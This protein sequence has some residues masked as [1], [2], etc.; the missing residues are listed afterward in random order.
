MVIYQY[1]CFTY[2]NFWIVS[3]ELAHTLLGQ[4]SRS[5][6]ASKIAMYGRTLIII[7]ACKRIQCEAHEKGRRRWNGVKFP[8]PRRWTFLRKRQL[9]ARGLT[10]WNKG[11][12][13]DF[14]AT[15]EI[16][17]TA[18]SYHPT[19]IRKYLAH[20]AALRFDALKHAAVV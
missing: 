3:L 6:M 12:F 14:S 9:D 16:F 4:F 17:S 19:R 15:L 13:L 7:L 2:F 11:F 1:F 8:V 5:K 18:S 20:Q 10:A